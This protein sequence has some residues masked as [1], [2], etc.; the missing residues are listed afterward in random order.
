M[1]A[2]ILR[3]ELP[4]TI[5][6]F[7]APGAELVHGLVADPGD[8]DRLPVLTKHAQEADQFKLLGQEAV[9]QRS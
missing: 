6:Q 7:L 2:H 3:L 5:P 1:V 4:G 8:L 9:S